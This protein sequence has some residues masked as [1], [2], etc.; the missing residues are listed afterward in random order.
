MIRLY[1]KRILRN[2]MA[3]TGLCLIVSLAAIAVF[4]PWIAPYDPLG[5]NLLERLQAPSLRHWLGTDD[6]GR[7]L[8]SRLLYG[9]R[10]SL[11]V[12]FVAVSIM[13]FFGTLVG[14]VAGYFGRW[15]D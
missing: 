11:T 12:A 4:A 6:L 8:L 2:R 13:T 1:L 15:W 7:D 9:T 10:V 5:Q 3:V 14:L